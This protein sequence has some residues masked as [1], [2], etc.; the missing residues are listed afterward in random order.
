[1]VIL[2]KVEERR[3]PKYMFMV[4]PVVTFGLAF[5]I[6]AILMYWAGVNPLSGYS[7]F[8]EGS[9]GSPTAIINSLVRMTPFLFMAVGI[10]FSNRVGVLNI[11][12]EGQYIMGAIMATWVTLIFQNITHPALSILLSLIVA[13]IVGA[14][15]AMFAGALKVYLGVNEIVTTVIM[16]W[17]AF[18]ILQWLLRGP[19]KSPESEMWPM[20]P[21]LKAHFPYIIPGTRLHLGFLIALILAVAAYYFLFKTNLG[22]KFRVTGSSPEVATYAG[23]DVKKFVLF[24][25]AFSGAMAGLAGASEVLGVFHFLYEGIAVGLGYT[26][27]IVALVGKNHPLAIIASAFMFGVIYNGVVFLQSATGLTYTFSKAI[28]GLIYLFFI[29]SEVL[30]LYRIRTIKVR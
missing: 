14:L 24:S 9:L 6:G 3:L 15:W 26:S 10:A 29:V 16:N 8:L 30:V 13:A 19:L 12:A 21:P 11:G 7:A 20:S 17:L 2:L 22:F 25:M 23:Y 4:I 28:E 27:I 1:V 18:K 5:L